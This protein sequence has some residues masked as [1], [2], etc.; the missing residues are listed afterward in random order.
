M[1][2]GKRA[3]LGI[4][5]VIA[6][7]LAGAVTGL[8]AV[9]GTGRP[10]APT[11]LAGSLSGVAAVSATDAWAVG[12]SRAYGVSSGSK[13]LILHWNG[14]VWKQVP[15]PG[16]KGSWLYGVA[17]VSATDAWV[18]GTIYSNG[19]T[20]DKTLI[21]HWNG[22]SWK[23]VPSPSPEI[24]SA[25]SGV[26]AVSA[27]DAWAVGGS[28][29][30]VAGSPIRRSVP[31]PQ[32]LL[33]HW[34]GKVWKQVASPGAG[35]TAVT[36]LSARSGWATGSTGDATLVLQWNGASWKR[37]P[38]PGPGVGGPGTSGPHGVAAASARD[39][40]VAGNSYT[41]PATFKTVILH[42]NGTSW[43]RVLS[44]SPT[45][46]V[47]FGVAAVSATDAWAVGE[48]GVTSTSRT[49]I[50]HWNGKAWSTE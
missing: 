24:I 5:A 26:A 50:L 35:L 29:N 7:V 14:K 18:V 41:F 42:W 19:N 16:P 22:A 17:A 40:W 27:T 11:A 28:T 10:T 21:L 36:F 31:G 34:N 48:S 44:P 38:S 4:W 12:S 20:R 30:V 32:T 1:L 47:L 9:A 2:A 45:A 3:L 37:V 8:P 43:K 33:L 46:S 6:V 39:A 25:L 13:T 49:L 15:S 23:Q